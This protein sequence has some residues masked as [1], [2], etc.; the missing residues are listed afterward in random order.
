M[1]DGEEGGEEGVGMIPPPPAVQ[2]IGGP[3]SWS[4][5]EQR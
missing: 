2:D 5:E 4:V 3:G 1:K